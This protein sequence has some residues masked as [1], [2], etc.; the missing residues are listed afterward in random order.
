M[1]T[2]FPQWHVDEVWLLPPSVQDLVPPGHV[3]HFVRDAVRDG[4]DLA[5]LM[6]TY[7]GD[8]DAPAFHPGM[9][10]ALLLYAYSQGI[11]ASRQI[12]RAC[13]DRLDFAAVTGLQ[14]PD[15]QAIADFRRRHASLLPRLFMQVLR[16]SH[17]IGLPQFGDIM[18]HR[19]PAKANASKRAS[20][21]IDA[22]L[23]AAVRGWLA[24]A[25]RADRLRT[26][27]DEGGGQP[28]WFA[29]RAG[30][31]AKI[32]EARAALEAEEDASTRRRRRSGRA[33]GPVTPG[34]DASAG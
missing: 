23:S 7:A 17:R 12:A 29:D 22:A 25:A 28:E 10:T 14:R 33:A 26:R 16:L 21:T 30:R 1:N 19:K 4:C 34:A 13:V 3:A 31:R 11:H 9:M 5:P 18:L 24:E 27:G 32:R 15:V 2:P 8:R 20:A 6:E